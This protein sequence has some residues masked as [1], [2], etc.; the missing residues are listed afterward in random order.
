[1]LPA[2]VSDEILGKDQH[3]YSKALALKES[4]LR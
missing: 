3:R 2:F 1:M 4:N